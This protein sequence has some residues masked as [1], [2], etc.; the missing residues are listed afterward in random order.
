MSVL[1]KELEEATRR[2]LQNRLERFIGYIQEESK[3]GIDNL[4]H[5]RPLLIKPLDWVKDLSSPNFPQPILVV[6]ANFILREDGI[7]ISWVNDLITINSLVE[8]PKL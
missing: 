6:K 3:K 8:T 4:A 5:G 1:K 2:S 7:E